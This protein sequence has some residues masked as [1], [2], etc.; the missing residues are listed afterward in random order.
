M[1]L[2]EYPTFFESFYFV[3][4]NNCQ[5]GLDA[6][7]ENIATYFNLFSVVKLILVKIW[8][9]SCNEFMSWSPKFPDV[10][11]PDVTWIV[12]LKQNSYLKV[13]PVNSCDHGDAFWTISRYFLMIRSKV[14]W[15]WKSIIFS[16]NYSI[17]A[18]WLWFLKLPNFQHH[19]TF[20]LIIKKYRDIVQ[21]A[22]PWSQ[23]FIGRTFRYEFFLGTF[24]K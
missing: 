24:L 3:R 1:N 17:I 18:Y 9:N 5:F 20:D 6:N 21:K 10:S 2:G 16:K 13:L 11:L 22:S 4:Q 7:I 12:S 14:M 8:D 15:Y 19:I 23:E